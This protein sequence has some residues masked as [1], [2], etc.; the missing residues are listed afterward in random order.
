MVS[1][2]V[3]LIDV[4]IGFTCYG[5]FDFYFAH[6]FTLMSTLF[7]SML[8]SLYIVP[9]DVCSVS[10][11]AISWWLFSCLM[12]VRSSDFI[13]QLVIAMLVG[14]DAIA[15][16]F[17]SCCMGL[18]VLHIIVCIYVYGH[19]V[20]SLLLSIACNVCCRCVKCHVGI[21]VL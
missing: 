8:P 11:A 12:S 3:I 16:D 13:I 7:A 2:I 1:S 20:I 9:T 15:P 19:S 17:S 18:S 5:Q 10:Q 21:Y 4:S 6:L 14:P